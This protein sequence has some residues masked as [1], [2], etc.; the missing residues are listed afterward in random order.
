MDFMA[1]GQGR[2][3]FPES[4]FISVMPNG[5]AVSLI[6]SQGN[7]LSVEVYGNNNNSNNNNN[8]STCSLPTSQCLQGL[9]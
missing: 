3:G 8:N 7:F 6:I 2:G 9:Y 5:K 1:L 4:S